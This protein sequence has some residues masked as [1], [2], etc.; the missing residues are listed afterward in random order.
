M[1]GTNLC[2]NSFLN[3]VNHYIVFAAKSS[4]SNL[5]KLKSKKNE[6]EINFCKLENLRIQKAICILVWCAA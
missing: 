6:N 1:L 3:S 2:K 5:Y 4:H